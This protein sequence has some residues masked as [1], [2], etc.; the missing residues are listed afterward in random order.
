MF[1]GHFAVALVAKR[2][3][4][5]LS[6]PLLF[7]AVQF[8]DILWPVFILLGIEHARIVPG[9]MEASP[10][11]LYD[12]PYSHSLATSILWSVLFAVPLLVVRRVRE[13]LVLGLCVFSHFVLDFVTHRPDLPLAPGSARRFGLGLWN[14]RAA[15][16][17][18]EAL[19]FI[20]GIAVYVRGTKATKR[21]GTIGFAI[22][23]VAL[24]AIWLGGAF[25]PPPPDIKVVAWSI[26]VSMPIILL[27]AW[28]VDHARRPTSVT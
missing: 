21:M 16:V 15:E 20:A 14:F 22:F 18:V 8:L 1:V 3:T 2:A 27:T 12:I 11:D 23:M 9:L 4:P 6:L 17:A 25:G 10:L 7:A 13:G 24:A 19:L 28:A 26:V 5:R